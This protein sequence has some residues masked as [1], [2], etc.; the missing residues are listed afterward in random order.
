MDP[1][2]NLS[3]VSKVNPQEKKKN[4]QVYEPKNTD[5]SLVII[6][7][8]WTDTWHYYQPN[9]II[10]ALINSP[11]N[12]SPEDDGQNGEEIGAVEFKEKT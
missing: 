7:F 1:N 4:I 2:Q 3:R 5:A 10:K 8:F 12:E 11:T 9:F 6:Q